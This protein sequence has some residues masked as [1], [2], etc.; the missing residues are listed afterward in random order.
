[1]ND[2]TFGYQHGD[3]VRDTRDGS[4]GTIYIKQLSSED[5]RDCDYSVM[6]EVRWGRGFAEELELAHPHL[7]RIPAGN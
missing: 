1:M 4:T 7:T 3:R 2:E 6:A 5:A